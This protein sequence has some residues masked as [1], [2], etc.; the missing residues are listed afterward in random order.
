VMRPVLSCFQALLVLWGK[1]LEQQVFE[2][3]G[4][5]CRFVC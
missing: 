2:F 4:D 5:Q 1:R 3:D